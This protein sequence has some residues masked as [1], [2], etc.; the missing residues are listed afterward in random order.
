MPAHRVSTS[1]L[2]LRGISKKTRNDA[3]CALTSAL[4]FQALAS[5]RN[6]LAMPRKPPGGDRFDLCAR[7]LTQADRLAVEVAARLLAELWEVGQKFHNAKLRVLRSILMSFGMTP[8]DR[9]NVSVPKPEAVN[10][11]AKFADKNWP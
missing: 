2:E 9:S 5:P 11:F 3:S 1:I 7:G 10:R 8:T 6:A 4:V